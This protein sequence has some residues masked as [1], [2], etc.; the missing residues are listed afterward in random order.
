MGIIGLKNSRGDPI[1]PDATKRFSKFA[2]RA[3][4]DRDAAILA[5]G[6]TAEIIGIKTR[7]RG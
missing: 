1:Q 2:D 3:G 4:F 7:H 5:L 6:G